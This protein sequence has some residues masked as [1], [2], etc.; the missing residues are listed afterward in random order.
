MFT[1]AW[2]VHKHARVEVEG[3]GQTQ[4]GLGPLDLVRA[5]L[6]VPNLILWGV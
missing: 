1:K 6:A 3:R 2:L 4:L 5:L